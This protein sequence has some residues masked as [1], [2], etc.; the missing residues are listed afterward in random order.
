ME[1]RA[2]RELV[3][4]LAAGGRMTITRD[5]ILASLLRRVLAAMRETKSD[6][7]QVKGDVLTF[8]TGDVR[9]P[10]GPDGQVLTADSAQPTGIR[11]EP[12]AVDQAAAYSWTGL[13]DWA[14]EGNMAAGLIVGGDGLQQQLRL[15]GRGGAP[16]AIRGGSVEFYK[17][18]S[19]VAG[20]L[21]ADASKINID[22]AAQSANNDQGIIWFDPATGDAEIGGDL[23]VLG[24]LVLT[25]DTDFNTGYVFDIWHDSPGPADGDWNVQFRGRG[26]NDIDQVQNFAALYFVS[27]VVADG[28]EEGEI[29]FNVQQDSVERM[30]LAIV[31]DATTPSVSLRT[32]TRLEFDATPAPGPGQI[33]TQGDTYALYNAGGP[34]LDFYV[35]GVLALALTQSG[36]G[37]GDSF[38][39]W[40]GA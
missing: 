24:S 6:I 2:R 14:L 10:V 33:T 3:A 39:E 25:T 1:S 15:K 40:A 36:V 18:A 31:G 17:S 7:L 32:G 30:L 8:D 29:L 12:V 22:A 20:Y 27:R 28:S 9:L 34:S 26:N 5:R 13:H 37:G 4:T 11:W 38:L 23:W 35:D 16:P 19:T 21:Y